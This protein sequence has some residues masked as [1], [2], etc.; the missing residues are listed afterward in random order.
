MMAGD[1]SSLLRQ[2]LQF[3]DRL[4]E[5]K[6]NLAV[7]FS[8][9]PYD[10]LA[11]LIHMDRL[12]TGFRRNV[13]ALLGGGPVLD[14]CC[15][16]GDLGFFLET[17]GC[18]VHAVDWPMTNRNFL[19]GAKALRQELKSSVEIHERDLDAQ[20]RLPGPHYSVT[21]FLGALY[22][23]KNPYFVLERIAHQTRYC[24]LSTRVARFTPD[25]KTR[26]ES[27]P[28]AYLVGPD[29]VNADNTNYWIFSES[30]L[31]QIL[32][33]TGWRVLEFT[34]ANPDCDSDP[35]HSH[36]DQRAFCLLES[37]YFDSHPVVL[38]REG[39]HELEDHVWRWTQERFVLRVEGLH[40]GRYALSLPVTLPEPVFQETGP[41]T[42]SAKAG[43][44]SLGYI[45]CPNP[46]D[47]RLEAELD[48]PEPEFDL[49]CQASASLAAEPSDR[50]E[51]ALIIKPD[52]L[53]E[54]IT[55]IAGD[56]S[57]CST[58]DGGAAD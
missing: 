52:D 3:R 47:Y 1:I 31:R 54:L 28:V 15:G 35:V 12:L 29:D 32:A 58:R 6:Q 45:S 34:L 5:I 39:W 8:W 36:N 48:D 11:N 43:S 33:R 46:G 14:L 40:R 56:D 4:S 9:Y 16:D 37:S 44:R 53:R 19:H 20:F 50:R 18:R 42:L 27:Y 7:D 25:H 38:L 24:F 49:V 13:A 30:G 51:R 57:G 55:R 22:H 2:G 17:L 10:S 23:L 41:I 21:F 26:I